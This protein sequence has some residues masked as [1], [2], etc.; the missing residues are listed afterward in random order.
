[1]SLSGRWGALPY[2]PCL[3]L[4]LFSVWSQPWLDGFLTH[5]L[6]STLLCNVNVFSSLSYAIADSFDV[7][8]CHCGLD[9]KPPESRSPTHA[10]NS[11]LPWISPPV[12][13]GFHFSN[14][15]SPDSDCAAHKCYNFPLPH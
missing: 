4:D 6:L 1:M 10:Q 12:S 9:G 5:L 13:N 7:S 8:R 2:A 3:L 11:F 15:K 14:S